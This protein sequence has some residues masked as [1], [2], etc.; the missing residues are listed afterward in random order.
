MAL[1]LTSLQ[2]AVEALDRSIKSYMKNQNNDSLTDDD[3]ETLKSGVIQ[4]FEVA[5][6]LCWKFMKRWIEENATGQTA[7]TL[8]LK[9]LF[10]MA[11]ERQ[12][13]KDVDAWFDYQKIRNLTSHTYDAD[14]AEEAFKTAAK[15]IFDAK[16]LL[17]NLESKND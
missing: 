8:T 10:R 3:K 9:E 12:L 2:K 1:D 6:E 4:N 11:F 15:F 14:N 16:E 5:Y 17:K 13:V 7:D